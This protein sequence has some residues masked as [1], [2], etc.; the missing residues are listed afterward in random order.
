MALV[1]LPYGHPRDAA[2]DPSA[3]GPIAGPAPPGP[4]RTSPACSPSGRRSSTTTGPAPRASPGRP[5]WPSPTRPTAGPS[6]PPGEDSA[7]VLRDPATGA[8]RLRLEGPRRRRDL[9]GLQPR[10]LDPRLG[11]L[12]PDRPALGRGDRPPP[13][14]PRGPHPV[15]LRPRL[16]PRRPDARLG[17]LRPDGPALGRRLGRATATLAGPASAIR[18]LAFSPDGKTLASAGADR[19]A[20]LWDL[21]A[22]RADPHAP[23]APGDDPAPWPSAPTAGTVATA[24]EDGEVRLWDPRS[25]R[26]RATLTGHADMV[27]ALAFTPSGATLASGGLDSTI[28]LWDPKTGRERATLH[29]HADGVPALAFAPGARRLASA[30]YD[31]TVKLWEA[32]APTLSAA[33]TLDYPGE[34]R[35]VAFGPRR[36]GPLRHRLRR[37]PRR[38]RP[39]R[40]PALR[41]G[42]ARRRL[43]PGRLP[44]RQAD[45]RR[46]PR[47][48]GP[49]GRRRDPPRG[50]DPR[51][52]RRR[53]PLAWPSA[54]AARSSPRAGSTARSSSGT[55][56]P[57]P[58]AGRSPGPAGPVAALRFS[59]DGR[60]LAVASE[61]RAGEVA[62]FDAGSGEPSGSLA[63]RGPDVA[64]VA[65]SPDGRTIATVGPD[66]TI[67]LFDAA[68]RSERASW[69]HPEGLVGRLRARRPVPGHRARDGEVVLWDAASGRKL[70]TLKGHSGAGLRR[71]LRARRP[72]GR[73]V[74]A[75]P[76]GPALEPGRPQG[77]APGEPERRAGLHRPGGHLARRQDPGRRR[78][79]LRLGRPHRPLGPRPADLRHAPR[80]R[81]RGRLAGLLARRQDPGLEQLGP[82]DPP[83]GR[84]DRRAPGRVRHH[85]GRRP[86]GVLARRQDPGRG[87]R[88]Q[89]PDP[90]GPR[91]PAPR[92]PGSRASGA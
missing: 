77:H 32:A 54:A 4:A 36:P 53:G 19:V 56:P 2:A 70:A 50:R 22:L 27:L 46:G 40:R 16:Q 21:R 1:V 74:G 52:P 88:G 82:D 69:N 44:R 60:T 91:E 3:A 11:R 85:R 24:G 80:P 37:R 7:I 81:A 76:D 71:R 43:E 34:A 23:G 58:G 51:G 49:P 41:A 5:S 68:T 72:D 57:G 38:L 90:L 59:P 64:S 29:G 39:D 89:G 17:R 47:R 79:G 25:G 48:Q 9:P 12:R 15:G 92:R 42:P 84:P 10:R 6:P 8:A 65:F 13:G 30:G 78:G 87:R 45:R 66:G 20:T 75:G 33:A 55:S 26:E 28:R 63:G 18:A 86:A 62:L 35:G 83:L 31:G 67:A 61:G 73:L 14:H